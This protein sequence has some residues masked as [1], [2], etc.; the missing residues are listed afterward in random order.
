LKDHARIDL[1]DLPTVIPAAIIKRAHF[2]STL[3]IAYKKPEETHVL[4]ASGY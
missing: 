4:Q 3:Q 1:E 2:H